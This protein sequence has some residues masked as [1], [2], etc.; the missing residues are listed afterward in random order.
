[1]KLAQQKTQ[2]VSLA[3]QYATA[4]VS[5]LCVGM[6]VLA[7]L[8]FYSQAKQNERYLKDFGS[9]I[10]EQ[11]ANAAAE[12]L[13]SGDKQALDDLLDN[14]STDAHVYGVG[15]FNRNKIIIS[16]KGK[17]PSYQH[18][19]PELGHYRIGDKWQLSDHQEPRLTIH[20]R[21]I[22][23]GMLEMGYIII[24]FSQE[25]F[26]KQL[27]EQLYSTL[28]IACLL[29][30]ISVIASLYLGKR[31]SSPITNLI[32]AAESIRHG[33]QDV[34]YERRNDELA[35][36]IDS[37]N[38]MSQGLIRKE[39][40]ESMLDK[41]LSKDV[42]NK[43]ME[44]FDSLD[45]SG[46]QVEAT[47]LFADIVGFTSISEKIP[48]DEVQQL[49]NEYYSYFNACSRFFFGTVD[50][51]IGDC[52]MVVFGATQKDD[53]HLYH[54][55]SCA[56]LMQRLA[57]QLNIR[58]QQQGLFPIELRIGIN[59]GKMVAGL[60]GSA[61]RMEYTVVG[62]AVNLASRLCNEAAESQIIIEESTFQRVSNKYKVKT[63]NKKQIRIRGKSEAVSIYNITGIE[64]GKHFAN[65]DLIDDILIS[66]FHR[67]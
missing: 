40:V 58:R 46:E 8:M 22:N 28:L 34:I 3:R 13:F 57:K 61:E 49:L 45:M 54:A 4:M 25:A 31:L 7:L 12:P 44:Q 65:Q 10:T 42:K 35:S 52:V 1:M 51:Y 20:I 32:L 24:A 60:I 43:V 33:K 56:L 48:A 2:Q 29:L 55:I 38:N 19:K 23:L 37:I 41:V 15:V 64:Q 16:S 21:P 27:R 66:R 62:D 11:L 50:K 6:S 59:T 17:L 5:L 18:I 36:L 63:D 9:I 53:D 14:L 26:D 67:S 30:L 47:V 39:Q